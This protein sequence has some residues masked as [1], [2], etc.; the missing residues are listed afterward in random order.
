MEFLPWSREWLFGALVRCRILGR[1]RCVSCH[2]CVGAHRRNREVR[3]RTSIITQPSASTRT[4]SA[5]VQAK[6]SAGL[7]GFT[8]TCS[9]CRGD[10]VVNLACCCPVQVGGPCVTCELRFK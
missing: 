5:R 10:I 4:Y 6:M 2:L 1:L 9:R 3:V 8:L 7:D